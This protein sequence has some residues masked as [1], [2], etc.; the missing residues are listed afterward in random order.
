MVNPIAF[1]K[2]FGE[3]IEST[4]IKALIEEKRGDKVSDVDCRGNPY[5]LICIIT[6]V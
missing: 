3:H 5:R 1:D 4:S 6:R 2:Q